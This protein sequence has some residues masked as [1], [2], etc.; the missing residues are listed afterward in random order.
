MVYGFLETCA[1]LNLRRLRSEREYL[2]ARLYV[3]T[4]GGGGPP[5]VFLPGLM[6]S[7]RYWNRQKLAPLA[8]SRRL[9]FLDE[10]G[11][12]RSPWP[13]SEYT[14]DNHL[15]AIRRTLVA[16][17]ATSHVIVVGHSFG[18]ILACLLCRAL[19]IRG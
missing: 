6:A 9:I 5:V 12:G 2:G 17:G 10:S 4:M 8:G 11:F 18:A 13:D 16:E 19:S 1:S 7:T 14:L 3:E 15:S